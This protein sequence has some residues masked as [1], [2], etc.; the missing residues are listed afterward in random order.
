MPTYHIKHVTK[1]SY[2]SEVTDSA[3]Q[4]ILSPPTTPYQD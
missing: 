4:I 1:Y 3:N 2:P